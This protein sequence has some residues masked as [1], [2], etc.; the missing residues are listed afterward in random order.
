MIR[1]VV[2]KH[3]TVFEKQSILENHSSFQYSKNILHLN[4]ASKHSFGG[5][6]GLSTPP[7][8][9]SLLNLVLATS[10]LNPSPTPF[11]FA[12]MPH[13]LCLG[14]L[15]VTRPSLDPRSFINLRSN[16]F[17]I[18]WLDQ[19]WHMQLVLVMLLISSFFW[20]VHPKSLSWWWEVGN[21]FILQ[22]TDLSSNPLSWFFFFRFI[23]RYN[24]HRTATVRRL[25]NRS[26]NDGWV[27]SLI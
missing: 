4:I 13:W 18:S 25:R 7:S 14:R 22:Q 3:P 1:F 19:H 16:P 6:F 17:S 23:D 24:I 9:L 8:S 11:Q 10:Y 26:A 12:S 21:S 2:F 15:S 20:T 5:Q 27:Q